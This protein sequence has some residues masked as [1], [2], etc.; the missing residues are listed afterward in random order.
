MTTDTDFPDP[1]TPKITPVDPN[2]TLGE[3]WQNEFPD[4]AKPITGIDAPKYPVDSWFAL[5]PTEFSARRP[6]TAE[7]VESVLWEFGVTHRSIHYWIG[8]ALLYCEA[9]FGDKWSQYVPDLPVYSL[10]TMQNDMWVCRA[11][12]P[13]RRRE[14]LSFGHHAV[15]A[16]LNEN[17]QDIFLLKAEDEN[18][19]VSTLSYLVT[20]SKRGAMPKPISLAR[21]LKADLRLRVEHLYEGLS[22][23]ADLPDPTG[24]IA[25]EINK[26]ETPLRALR[27]DVVYRALRMAEIDLDSYYAHNPDEILPTDETL[28]LDR[29]VVRFRAW[30]DEWANTMERK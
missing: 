1:F 9:R 19:S 13:S 30:L 21:A 7:E 17:L 27:P 2:L 22:R 16:A 4:A 5:T 28:R 10:K 24:L 26:I 23:I 11:I 18:L 14:A 3:E 25:L 6:A 15:V 20:V 8:D 12:N 29:R